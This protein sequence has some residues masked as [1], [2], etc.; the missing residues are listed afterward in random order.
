MPEIS[1][2]ALVIGSRDEAVTSAI[3]TSLEGVEVTR[4]REARRADPVTVFAVGTGVVKLVDA[5]LA[6]MKRLSESPDAPS[7]EI[8]TPD[9]RAISL[10]NA[11]PELLTA[12]LG[13]TA[14]PGS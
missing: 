2:V 12:A 1:A 6:L 4:W 8:R 3:V 11:T 10:K 7:V 14:S 13:A 9:G 5:L